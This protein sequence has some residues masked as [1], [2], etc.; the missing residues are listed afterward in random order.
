M[1]T[2][3]KTPKCKNSYQKWND[4]ETAGCDGFCKRTLIMNS[5]FLKND[6]T[7]F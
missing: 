3:S 1:R 6:S 4:L 2:C 5:K 7:N